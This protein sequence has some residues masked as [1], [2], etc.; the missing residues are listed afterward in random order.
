M[1]IQNLYAAE[2]WDKIYSAFENVNFVSYDY[3]TIKR[4]LI[5]Y[6]KFY[7][8]EDFNDYI[9][10]SQFIALI[11]VFSYV[12]EQLAYRIDMVAHENF[13]STAERKQS[14]L[15]LA[16]LVSYNATRNI[17]LRG[18]V[19]LSAV[20]CSE[21]VIDSHGN[22]LTNR[23]IVWNDPNNPLWK[24]QFFLV[25]DRIMSKPFGQPLKSFQV[26][27]VVFQQYELKNNVGD[28]DVF[29]NGVFSYSV[30]VGDEIVKMEV[31][32]TDLDESGP[33]EKTPSLTAQMTMLYCN[34][35][36]GDGSEMTGF[37]M[38][39]K[40]GSLQRLE[41]TMSN[42]IPN[43]FIDIALDNIND[44]D[45]WVQ[46]VDF[47]GQ[48]ADIW[49]KTE[50]INS[51][52]IYFNTQKSRK[53]YEVET[54]ENDRIRLNFGD[55]DYS[56]IPLGTF[57]IWVRQ[58][59]NKNLVLQKSKVINKSLQFGYISKLDINESATFRF[60]LISTL[61][62]GSMSED[63]E[64]IRSTAPKTYYSQNRMV[65]GQDYNTFMLKDP[66][67]LRLR[68]VNR[69]FAGQ[70][71]YLEWNDA[72]GQYQNI[73]LFGNDLR[74]YWDFKKQSFISNSSSRNLIDS[75]LEP[76]LKTN[77][78]INM[79][80][81][82]NA[83]DP[84]TAGL[85]IN[86]RQ[87]FIEETKILYRG[88]DTQNHPLLEKTE[89][90]GRLDRHFYGEPSRVVKI[91]DVLHAVVD[92]DPDHRI[93]DENMKLSL[94][95]IVTYNNFADSVSG[96]QETVQ[97]FKRFGLRY[98]NTRDMVGNGT[99]TN[100][101]ISGSNDE[102]WNIQLINEV[103]GG[104]TFLVTGSI[105]G[106]AWTTSVGEDF[107]NGKISFKIMVDLTDLTDFVLGDSFVI[108]GWGDATTVNL[109]GRWEIIEESDLTANI[110]DMKFDQNDPVNSWLIIVE[111]VDD[112]EGNLL[113]W[114]IIYRD[115]RMIV[116]SPTTKFWYNN[117]NFIV[118]RV[119]KK[120]VRDSVTLLKSNTRKRLINDSFYDIALGKNEVYDVMDAVRYNNGDVN[121]N[122]LLVMPTDSSGSL[123]SGDGAPDN[124][125]Q[126]TE[127]VNINYDYVYFK[128]NNVDDKLQPVVAT[129]YVRGLTY[130]D[131]VAG[132]YVRK[133]GKDELDFL[134]LHYSPNTNLI[135]PSTSNI[136]DTFVLTRG[137][138]S[139]VINY[140]NGVSSLMP[141]PPTSLELRTSYRAL[142]DKKMISD[143]VVMHSG[144]I[145]L[146]FG[147]LADAQLRS[148]FRVIQSP[149]ATMT[150]DQ[151]KV[152]VLNIINEY[153]TI[154]R[155]DFGQTFYATELLA[156]I[157]QRM[158]SEVSSVVIVPT[159]V[160]NY[161]GSLFIIEAGYDEVL[162]SAATINDIEVTETFNRIN[163]RQKA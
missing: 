97:A 58:S 143:T 74:I 66:S 5:D 86:P 114:D 104:G 29:K 109:A 126:F 163:L 20:S 49:E 85:V 15:R 67:I 77:G 82:I 151:V 98:I 71:K 33:F 79:V 75:V 1:A 40:Q 118:D 46:R 12:A 146:L 36:L 48:I 13:I 117:E 51:Q 148:K 122:A 60:S 62:N 25:M 162:Q 53:K 145:K 156:L 93:Y 19:K 90:Q 134:W 50:T 115:L 14:I 155:W 110:V 101:D 128:V 140:V 149:D 137:Y 91:N 100:L 57:H 10:S 37:M 121:N 131:D 157:H 63:I 150:K 6:V 154:E 80:S 45:V 89:I 54:L 123:L 133:I 42:P 52:N 65:N 55:G 72:S 103:T 132:E 38:M 119:T 4:S 136:I 161:F 138:Y 111:R 18:L 142:L 78:M 7:Y 28:R 64:H 147:T 73:K 34:D 2:T 27:D 8:P 96:I 44:I 116:E 159:F 26:D 129:P 24:D 84:I 139:E 87:K 112:I 107:T 47:S 120:R 16:K 32:P 102:D 35:G 70:P 88:K 95:G 106:A 81:Y 17:P 105:S 11:E 108:Q 152:S 59:L 43:N 69:T 94:D 76:I 130:V 153:F 158:A 99:L 144:K 22:N 21:E 39:T 92:T 127:F 30:N 141:L 113:H 56:E 9:E 61:Q 68:S 160:E 135:D 125:L 124:S 41:I 83:M 3:D 23:N 31:T